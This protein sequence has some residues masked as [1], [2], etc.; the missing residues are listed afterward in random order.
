MF[1]KTL[2]YK[3]VKKIFFEMFNNSTVLQLHNWKAG[4]WG[5]ATHVFLVSGYSDVATISKM[6]TPTVKVNENK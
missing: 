5:D 4:I 3:T 6:V 1:T 2:D